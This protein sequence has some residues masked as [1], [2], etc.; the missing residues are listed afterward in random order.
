MMQSTTRTAYRR[1]LKQGTAG[2]LSCSLAIAN[3]NAAEQFFRLPAP[4]VHGRTHTYDIVVCQGDPRL[5]VS[6]DLPADWAKSDESSPTKPPVD[7]KGPQSTASS[8]ASVQHDSVDQSGQV[9]ITPGEPG[10]STISF[11]MVLDTLTGRTGTITVVIHV[12]VLPASD[13]FC[14]DPIPRRPD[15]PPP[16][17]GPPPVVVSTRTPTHRQT[18]CPQCRAAAAKLNATIDQLSALRQQEQSAKG[19]TLVSLQTQDQ[20]LLKQI[21]ALAAALTACEKGCVTTVPDQTMTTPPV[22]LPAKPARQDNAL[23]N[24]T[25]NPVPMPTSFPSLNP[26]AETSVPATTPASPSVTPIMPYA[27][28]LLPFH[29]G[30]RSRSA[31]SDRPQTVQPV[32]TPAAI[33]RDE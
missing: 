23:R 29:G 4:V 33:S 12:T 15:P 9:N 5:R 16:G 28:T 22:Q 18:N 24:V 25:P 8:V 10:T 3:A 17:G 30:D 19:A 14:Q 31:Q 7:I 32:T 26:S 2:L 6:P 21:D 11:N 13:P 20:G 27:P 1:V